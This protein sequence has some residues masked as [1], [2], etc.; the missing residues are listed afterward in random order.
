MTIRYHLNTLFLLVLL[1]AA[2]AADAQVQPQLAERYFKEATTLCERDAGRLWGVS[3]CGPL[4]IFDPATGT[5][6]TNRP[7]PEGPPPRFPGVVDGPVSWGGVRWFA[8]PLYMLPEKDADLRQQLLLHALFHRIQ[9]ELGFITDDGFNEHLD[10][11]E[12]RV[13]MQL[14]W[15]ALRRA[16]ES[17]ASERAEAIADALAFRRE[18]R[19]LFPGAADNERRDEI[20]EG[21]ASYTGIAAWANSPADARRAAAAA[22]AG[23]EGSHSFVGNFEA[24]SGPAYGVLLDDLLPGWRR[25]VRGTSD[26]GDLLVSATNKPP[27]TDVAVAAAR[28]DGATLRTAEEARDRAQQVR[29]AELRR[30]FVDGPVLTVPAGGRGTSD[31]TGSVGIPGVGTVFFRNFT[32]S[33]QWGRLDADGGVLRAADGATLSVPVTAPL[34]GTTLKGDGWRVTLNA[35]WVLQPAARPG[36]FTIVREKLLF[37]KQNVRRTNQ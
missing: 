22:V 30:R 35:G 15:R 32:L 29:V 2:A 1:S 33:A 21:L 4:V 24:A 17:I 25:Q 16:V 18:R 12:G 36:S 10:T 9:P 14:E 13:W 7:E 27:T 11:L 6:A 19:R 31:T 23:A 20:R 34:E 26:L 3:L 37:P 8:M 5:R 28:H